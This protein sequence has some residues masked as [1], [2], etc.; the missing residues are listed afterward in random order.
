MRSMTQWVLTGLAV[1]LLLVAPARVARASDAGLTPECHK[2]IM[3]VTVHYLAAGLGALLKDIPDEAQRA[4]AIKRLVEDNYIFDDKSGYLFV[5]NFDGENI[6]HGEKTMRGR[7]LAQY[8]EGKGA[9]LH[10]TFLNAV[11]NNGGY[12]RYR[13][14]KP[15]QRV[16]LDVIAYVEQIPGT[17]YYI[18]GGVFLY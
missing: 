14:H 5:Y 11:R 1:G 6:A 12:G 7:N 10:K 17:N 2:E 9:D 8:N 3:R 16:T 4:Q 15:G 18:G 13:F